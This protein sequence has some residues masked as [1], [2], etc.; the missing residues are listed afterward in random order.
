VKGSAST[1]NLKESREVGIGAKILID[2]NH[3]HI[4]NVFLISFSGQ[5][6]FIDD[7]RFEVQYD[8]TDLIDSLKFLGV[9]SIFDKVPRL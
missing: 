9:H 3:N 7:L 8:W 6:V 5:K 2:L 4:K 1:F